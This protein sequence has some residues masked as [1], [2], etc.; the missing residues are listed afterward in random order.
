MARCVCDSGAAGIFVADRLAQD[1]LPAAGASADY[2]RGAA[3]AADRYGEGVDRCGCGSDAS[4]AAMGRFAE[5]A[6]DVGDAD[7]QG[8][9]RSGLVFCDGLV[10]DFPGG[11]G[12]CAEERIGGG[13][14]SVSCG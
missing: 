1:V 10:S 4:V 6:A 7:F 5:A 12:N 3:D 13:V 14:D 2:G 11:E 8:A 9:D